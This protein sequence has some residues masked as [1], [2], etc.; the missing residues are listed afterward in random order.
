MGRSSGPPIF[1]APGF[2]V[3]DFCPD[4]CLPT[5]KAIAA[6]AR[7]WFAER[8][9]TLEKTATSQQGA[10]LESPIEKAVR[11][12]S[13]PP[14]PDDWRQAFE[15]IKNET[16][17]RLRNLLHE[18]KLHGYYFDNGGP[19]K[20]SRE[21]WATAEADGVL[22]SGVVWP[23]GRPSR[24]YEQR[25]N[26]LLFLLQLELDTLLSAEPAKKRPLP[27]SQMSN[28]AAALRELGELPNRQAQ[29]QALCELPQFREFEIT[30]ADFRTAARHVPRKRGRKSRQESRR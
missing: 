8:F 9:T 28:L 5:V 13:Q 20:M 18:G 29:Y 1:V 12:F 27:R 6:A 22:E 21:F 24:V 2:T 17:N 30:R 25:P 3:I 26:Y 14:I 4:G 11:V 23:F 19:H 16:V 7:R 15:E 10:E